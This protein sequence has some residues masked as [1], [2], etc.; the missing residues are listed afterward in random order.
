MGS[1]LPFASLGGGCEG[2][3]KSKEEERA[4][5]G[6]YGAGSAG[7]QQQKPQLKPPEPPPASACV[8]FPGPLSTKGIHCER[9]NENGVQSV[10]GLH[11][12]GGAWRQGPVQ[13]LAP[14]SSCG[15][16]TGDPLGCLEGEKQKE[17]PQSLHSQE[18]TWG[19]CSPPGSVCACRQSVGDGGARVGVG[20]VCV[21]V[22]V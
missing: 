12:K 3:A 17:N 18:G 13:G 9:E 2:V 22:C 1:V 15:A 10:L 19:L 16:C 4:R 14:A 21:Y 11:Q 7:H 5:E 20:G 8:S 6:S